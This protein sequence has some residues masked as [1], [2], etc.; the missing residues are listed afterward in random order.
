MLTWHKDG[1][2][3][4]GL[5]QS[6]TNSF[7][8][9]HINE[10][11]PCFVSDAHNIRLGLALDGVNPF[12]DLSSCHLTWPVI[13]LNYNLPPWMVTKQFF[14]MLA[15]IILGKESMKFENVDLYLQP[16]IEELQ[17]LWTSVKTFDIISTK[18]LNLQ[19]MCMW[20]VHDFPTYEL[21]V[22]CVTKGHNGCPP[23][24]LATKS[25]FSMKLKKMV[26]CGIRCY[27][28]RNHTY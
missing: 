3:I 27:L 22:G 20:S 4:N 7:A 14:L 12:S 17:V 2:N 19:A 28:R 5:V 6:V 26:D 1:Y 21:F 23:C 16:F 25:Y 13:L 9:K 10:K 8:W 24:G 18:K 11:W 15:F